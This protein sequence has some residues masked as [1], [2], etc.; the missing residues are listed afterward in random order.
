MDI[1]HTDDPVASQLRQEVF[2]AYQRPAGDGSI[3]DAII[4]HAARSE[5]AAPRGSLSADLLRHHREAGG[6]V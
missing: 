6:T 1:G 2:N 3:A 5:A 4:K